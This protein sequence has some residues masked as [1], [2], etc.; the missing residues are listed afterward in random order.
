[1]RA[2]VQ[3]LVGEERQKRR[4]VH[5]EQREDGDDDQE[6]ADDRLAP[7][8]GRAARQ[9]R[10]QRLFLVV[11]LH[12]GEVAHQQQRRDGRQIAHGVQEEADGHADDGDQHTC[13][14]RSDHGRGVEDRGVEGDGVQQVL[15]ADKLDLE[16]LPTR[17]VEGID[18]PGDKRRDDD[19]PVLR[20][21]GGR[22]HEQGEGRDDE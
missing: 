19:L 12:R 4:A 2:D 5:R 3:H 1:V 16:R 15:L 14:R 11:V 9:A 20:M 22:E 10:A 7:S 8:V 6:Q 17:D 21:A 13:D 18:R